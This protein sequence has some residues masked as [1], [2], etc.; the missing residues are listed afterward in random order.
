M[1]STWEQHDQA[2]VPTLTTVLSDHM[3]LNAFC[4]DNGSFVYAA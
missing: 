2:D 4:P 3:S 1:L